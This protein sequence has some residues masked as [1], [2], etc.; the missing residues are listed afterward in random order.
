VGQVPDQRCLVGLIGAGIA[1][2]VS[3][4]LHEREADHLGLRYLYQL[5]DLDH[6]AVSADVVGSVLAGARRL[7][8]RG[9][10]VTHPCKRLVVPYLDDLSPE[11]AAVGAVNTI[12]FDD[13]RAVGHNTDVFGFEQNFFRGLPGAATGV[14]VI[15]G[16]G[17]AGAAVT[18]AMLELGAGRVVVVDP[19]EDRARVLVG[20]V[21]NRFGTERATLGAPDAISEDL[22]QADGL[23]NASPVG[24]TGH[25]GSPIDPDLL[26]PHTW[27]ADIVYRP[28]ETELLAGARS[29]G[30]RGLDGGGMA[31]FQAVGA[32]EI[33]TGRKPNA[34]RM[35]EHFATLVRSNGEASAGHA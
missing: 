16:A 21:W 33:F 4:A 29:R 8:F 13:G 19:D 2:S 34:D 22:R 23:I 7:G 25:P 26:R 11:A 24:M 12:V 27:V 3:P 14:V 5:I 9:L 31:V 35:L 10:N 20:S 17:G 28:L 1:T 15:L 6:L 30:C 18:T 32:F